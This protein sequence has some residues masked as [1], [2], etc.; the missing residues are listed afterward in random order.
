[1]EKVCIAIGAFKIFVVRNRTKP[2]T[3]TFPFTPKPKGVAKK[4]FYDSFWKRTKE[5]LTEVP[6][7]VTGLKIRWGKPNM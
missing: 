1:M 4:E 7:G 2:L 6:E 5:C 3:K